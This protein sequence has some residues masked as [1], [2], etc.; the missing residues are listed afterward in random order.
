MLMWLFRAMLPMLT[1]VEALLMLCSAGETAHCQQIPVTFHCKHR[2]SI[3]MLWASKTV[4][5]EASVPYFTFSLY[6]SNNFI[7][8]SN[9]FI[10]NTICTVRKHKKLQYCKKKEAETSGVCLTWVCTQLWAFAFWSIYLEVC[11]R[12]RGGDSDLLALTQ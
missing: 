10:E 6:F 12:G 9:K 8:A 5:R 1:P 4:F 2:S 11:V 7:L 3:L